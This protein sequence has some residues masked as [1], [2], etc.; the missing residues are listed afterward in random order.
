M[1]LKPKQLIID[2]NVF[3]GTG[4]KQ[5][6]RFVKK[7]FLILPYV[8]FYECF[9][10]QEDAKQKLPSRL[11]DVMLA[12]GYMCPNINHIVREEGRTLQP[13]GY[14]P[15]LSE[16]LAI[17]K[18]FEKSTNI[19]KSPSIKNLQREAMASA[20]ELRDLANR[21]NIEMI[22]E[23]PEGTKAARKSEINRLGQL[24]RWLDLIDQEDIHKLMVDKDKG[25]DL[26][27]SPDKYCLSPDWVSW[28]Y[29]RLRCVRCSE[30]SVLTIRSGT[31]TNERAEHD[32]QDLEYVLLLSR[33]DG[34]LTQDKECI[35]LA[36]AAFPDKDVFP[37]ITKVPNEY[38]CHWS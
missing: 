37:D 30:A 2:K 5:L 24:K 22:S 26:T 16:T 38:V 12:G 17:R 29:F 15:D 25:R 35:C 11:R 31:M 7:H 1:E 14:L 19:Y 10:D 20:Q 13:Y 18:V 36:K 28:H 32:L 4:T 21:V 9:T 34:L 6:C 23:E 33:A 27:N 3:Q 8:L